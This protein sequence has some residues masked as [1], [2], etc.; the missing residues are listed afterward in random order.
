MEGGMKGLALTVGS[1]FAVI[2]VE[3]VA[4]ARLK[5]VKGDADNWTKEGVGGKPILPATGVVKMSR[6]GADRPVIFEYKSGKKIKLPRLVAPTSTAEKTCKLKKVDVAGVK[7][8]GELF[9][10]VVPPGTEEA[11]ATDPTEEANGF[12][13][14]GDSGPFFGV[15]TVL[16]AGGRF[17]QNGI[18]KQVILKDGFELKITRP[19]GHG[20][21]FTPKPAIPEGE[22]KTEPLPRFDGREVFAG[23]FRCVDPYDGEVTKAVVLFDPPALRAFKAGDKLLGQTLAENEKVTLKTSFES[24]AFE[25]CDEDKTAELGTHRFD[26]SVEITATVGTKDVAGKGLAKG[27]AFH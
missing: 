24:Y 14:G 16:V 15:P 1:L 19:D 25:D 22:K 18:Y 9:Q 4:L 11:P 12:D 8:N 26:W 27:N 23:Q 6:S 21:K 17:Y 3:S 20:I 7:F 2:C 10:R 13:G 5:P